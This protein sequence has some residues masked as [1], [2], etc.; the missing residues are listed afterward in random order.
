MTHD[1]AN[2]ETELALSTAARKA[3]IASD[4]LNAQIRKRNDKLKAEADKQNAQRKAKGL[5]KLPPPALEPLGQLALDHRTQINAD[6]RAYRSIKKRT[7]AE[8]VKALEELSLEAHLKSEVACII[9]WDFFA[10]RSAGQRWNE[11]DA[12]LSHRF[13]PGDPD[14]VALSLYR[15]GYPAFTANRRLSSTGR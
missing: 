14:S 4:K 3:Q 1:P 2:F 6:E 8:W 11:L 5:S 7:A 9:W 10:T 13:K 12:H 15:I